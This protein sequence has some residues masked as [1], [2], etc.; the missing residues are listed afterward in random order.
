MIADLEQIIGVTVREVFGTML[1]LPI[2]PDTASQ[3]VGGETQIA[4]SVGFIGQL[5][6]VV[7]LYCGASFA[8]RITANLLGLTATET[9][10]AEMVNDAMGEMANMVVGNLKSR[11]ADRGFPCVL[12]IPSVFRGE[13]FGIGS[14][15]SAKRRVFFF[16]CEQSQLVVEVLFKESNS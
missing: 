1:H 8:G 16:R 12:S 7:Y 11:L 4:S 13:E 9:A 6:G 10:A 15:S 3:L 5:S 2:G 14:V